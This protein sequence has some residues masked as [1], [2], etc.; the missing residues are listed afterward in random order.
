[1]SARNKKACI[2]RNKVEVNNGRPQYAKCIN[3]RGP[4]QKGRQVLRCVE[5]RKEDR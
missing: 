5:C 1:M 2:G 4:K 3:K